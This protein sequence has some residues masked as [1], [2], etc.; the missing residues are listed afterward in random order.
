MLIDYCT[1]FISCL[2]HHCQTN[3]A[4]ALMQPAW[5]LAIYHS[6]FTVRLLYFTQSFTHS[7]KHCLYAHI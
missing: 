2:M 4:L 5:Q 6:N 1:G 3:S 7:F